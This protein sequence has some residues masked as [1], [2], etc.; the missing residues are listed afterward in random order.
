[1]VRKGEINGAP[2]KLCSG[3]EHRDASISLCK[4]IANA[5]EF[6]IA[7]EHLDRST[8]RNRSNRRRKIIFAKRSKINASRFSEPEQFFAGAPLISPLWTNSIFQRRFDRF[9]CLDRSRWSKTIERLL[10]FALCLH[11]E[12]D[13]SGFSGPEQSSGGAPLISPYFESAIF[14]RRYDR[15]HS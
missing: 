9:R 5:E 6:S 8:H 3:P 14:R 4:R 10:A 11:K 1:M 7:F 12:I 2:A 15:F 13:A